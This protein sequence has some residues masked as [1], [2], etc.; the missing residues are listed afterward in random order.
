MEVDLWEF[1]TSRECKNAYKTF[2]D[3]LNILIS[4]S[5]KGNGVI[6]LDKVYYNKKMIEILKDTI[7][8]MLIGKAESFDLTDKIQQAFQNKMLV[9]LRKKLHK[10]R[11]L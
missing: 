2:K 3:D 4:K 7:K 10:H 6:I 11:K 9:W 5:D 1:R 8:F